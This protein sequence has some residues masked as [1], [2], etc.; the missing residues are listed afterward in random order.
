MTDH[1]AI[2]RRLHA[3]EAYVAEL[4]HLAATVSRDEFNAELSTQWMIEHG[5]QLAIE[6]VLDIGNHLVAG[7]QLGTPQSYREIIELLGQGGILPEDFVTRVRGMPGFRNVLV[8]DYLAVDPGIVWDML[9][10]GPAQFREFMSRIAA[11][12]RGVHA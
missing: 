8:H 1:E 7:E 11:H 3:L 5:L 4:E 12:L 6:Y 9:H 10:D 2:C